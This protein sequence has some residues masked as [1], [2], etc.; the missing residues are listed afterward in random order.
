MNKIEVE[1]SLGIWELTKPKAGIRN[2]ALARAE[3]DSGSVR[4]IVFMTEILPR[5][6][7]RRPEGC[8]KEVPI[9]KLLDSLEIEDYDSLIEGVDNLLEGK[10]DEDSDNKKKA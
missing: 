6:V 4:K 2:R 5:M 10:Q 3:T 9:E 8:D 7:T 1:T